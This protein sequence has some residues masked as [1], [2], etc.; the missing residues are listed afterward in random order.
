MRTLKLFFVIVICLL[1]IH[2]TTVNIR[3]YNIQR[4]VEGIVDEERRENLRKAVVDG[5]DGTV[6]VTLTYY[7]PVEEQCDST[8]L[9]TA[10][11]SRIDLERLRDGKIR[12]CAISQDL[13]KKFPFGSRVSIDGVGE[14]YVRDVMNQRHRNRIDIL[15]YPGKTMRLPKGRVA[16]RKV[17]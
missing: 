14:Y 17:G 7:H 6:M 16:A 11:N 1:G 10:D 15:V 8:P 9:I 13:R 3:L 12:W 5:M 4:M 2:V